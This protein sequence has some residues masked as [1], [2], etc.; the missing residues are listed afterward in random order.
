MFSSQMHKGT[1]EG[2]G[3]ERGQGGSAEV[4]QHGF[5]LKYMQVSFVVF[6][7]GFF[8]VMFCSCN[9]PAP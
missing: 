4:M 8:C 6:V 3:S 7:L 5:V 2:G 9:L 1:G